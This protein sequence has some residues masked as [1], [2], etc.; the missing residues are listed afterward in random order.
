MEGIEPSNQVC[1]SSVFSLFR[2][3]PLPQLGTNATYRHIVFLFADFFGSHLHRNNIE[4]PTSVSFQT[5]ACAELFDSFQSA[6]ILY[7]A[8]TAAT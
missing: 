6:G 2:S 7:M 8:E 3:E 5:F 4:V 1:S